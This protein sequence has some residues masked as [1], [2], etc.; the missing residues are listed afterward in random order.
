MD[1]NQRGMS[2]ATIQQNLQ[3]GM[4]KASVIQLLGSPR[5]IFRNENGS[6]T[7]AYDWNSSQTQKKSATNGWTLGVLG[8]SGVDKKVRHSSQS[9]TLILHFSEKGKLQNFSYRDTSF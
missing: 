2:V 5:M 6:E 8:A 1:S 3:K 4:E 7:W 9:L